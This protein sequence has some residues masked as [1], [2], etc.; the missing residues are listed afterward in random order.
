M[1]AVAEYERKKRQRRIDKHLSK[2]VSDVDTFRLLMR[3]TGSVLV[4]DVASTF[5]NELPDEA[6]KG[7]K[8]QLFFPVT[9]FECDLRSWFSFFM[10]ECRISGQLLSIQSI[11]DEK[12]CSAK[13]MNWSRMDLNLTKSM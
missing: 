12:V 4:G 8:L 2:F 6:Q 9:N 1:Y 11:E 7:N 13:D 10:R 5:F 3:E